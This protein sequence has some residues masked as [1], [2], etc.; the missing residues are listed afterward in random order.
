MLFSNTHM[1]CSIRW[2]ICASIVSPSTAVDVLVLAQVH[3]MY[4]RLPVPLVL[5]TL[6]LLS[7]PLSEKISL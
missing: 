4:H 2:N 6:W 5:S 3:T 7:F 1:T